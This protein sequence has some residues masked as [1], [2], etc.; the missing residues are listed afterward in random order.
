[1]MNRRRGGREVAVGDVDRDPLL[2]L[3]AQA[4]GQQRQVERALA[5]AALARLRDVLELVLEDLL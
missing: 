4:V 1:M 3:G 2:A 5:A